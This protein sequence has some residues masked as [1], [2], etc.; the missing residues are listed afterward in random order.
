MTSTL[1]NTALGA[2]LLALTL[3]SSCSSKKTDAAA[4]PGSTDVT[5]S[6]TLALSGADTAA[7]L[8]ATSYQLYC[9]TFS[10]TPTAGFADADA[11]GA[12]SEKMEGF[13]DSP[14]GCFL[15]ADNKVLGS[16]VFEADSGQ[17]T[18]LEI[19][20]GEFTMDIVF[21]VKTG[22]VVAKNLGGSSVTG[23]ESENK[24]AGATGIPTIKGTYTMECNT[25]DVM[26]NQLRSDEFASKTSEEK[27]AL[28]CPEDM[29]GDEGMTLYLNDE[30]RSSDGKRFIGVWASEDAFNACIGDSG[31]EFDPNFRL[32]IDGTEYSMDYSSQAKYEESLDTIY[33]ALPAELKTALY[34]SVL[35][36]QEQRFGWCRE[37]ADNTYTEDKCKFYIPEMQKCWKFD[38]ETDSHKEVDCYPKWYE[39]YSDIPASATFEGT[40]VAKEITCRKDGKEGYR[41]CNWDTEVD[42]DGFGTATIYVTEDGEDGKEIMFACQLGD[43][44]ENRNAEAATLAEQIAAS[45]PPGADQCEDTDIA[46]YAGLKKGSVFDLRRLISDVFGSDKEGG[47]GDSSS[48]C[49]MYSVPSGFTFASCETSRNLAACWQYSSMGMEIGSD[50]TLDAA[51]GD[52]MGWF[53]MDKADDFC[54]TA[55]AGFSN[56]NKYNTD[57]QNLCRAEFASKS[58]A[59]QAELLNQ[60]A[61]SYDIVS[62]L[63][64]NGSDSLK[65]IIASAKSSS[66]AA[67]VRYDQMWVGN[68]GKVTMT[69]GGADKCYDSDGNFVGD[70]SARFALMELK[71]K[72]NNFSMSDFRK[73]Q[74]MNWDPETNE[75]SLCTEFNKTIISSNDRAESGGFI[76]QFA[77]MFEEKSDSKCEK[78]GSDDSSSADLKDGR[79]DNNG[80]FGFVF[81]RQ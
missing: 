50:G 70:L 49:D 12:F 22:T 9:V 48:V 24:L 28:L 75:Q 62:D 66:C 58:A 37:M 2:A 27:A 42:E 38:P 32:A 5:F 68:E 39:T 60:L 30:T 81:T 13:A 6:G 77:A 47:G 26:V 8:L 35:T 34:N 63:Q 57:S 55:A 18:T 79:E 53:P 73:Y 14:F 56:Q 74:Y 7:S 19:G 16:V 45:T 10:L 31:S 25:D 17:D 80:P 11:D 4:T 51:S 20:A 3:G 23:G 33:P 76:T 15:R 69:C 1:K 46:A 67:R 40:G 54:P 44:F 21:D 64:C 65:S 36:T 41:W 29:G 78:V 72:G 59:A 61:L 71:G 52:N 43:R